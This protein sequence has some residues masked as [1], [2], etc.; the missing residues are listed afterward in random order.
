MLNRI[1]IANLH[2]TSHILIVS[3]HSSQIKIMT[4]EKLRMDTLRLGLME[5]IDDC[6]EVFDI[7]L[8][9]LFNVIDL[10]HKDPITSYAN[11]D[12]VFINQMMFNKLTHLRKLVEGVGYEAKNGTKMNKIID[13]TIIASLTRNVYETVSIFSLDI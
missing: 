3:K 6:F 12:A 2:A 7:F 11:K 9:H 5:N 1:V 13:P 4:K 10:H 8:E